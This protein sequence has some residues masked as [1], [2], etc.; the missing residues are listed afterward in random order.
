MNR[1]LLSCM[2]L[3]WIDLGTGVAEE[4]P[5]EGFD[6]DRFFRARI[7]PIL[8]S[9]CYECH[10]HQRKIEG[11]LALDSKAGWQEGGAVKPGDLK[12]SPLIKAIRHLDANS[13]MPPNEKLPVAEIALLETWVMLGAPDPRTS[14]PK[15]AKKR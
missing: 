11:D 3:L 7:E 4:K 6:A 5:A 14:H 15:T 10:S 2:F 8:E 12:H 13:A 1:V 9:R